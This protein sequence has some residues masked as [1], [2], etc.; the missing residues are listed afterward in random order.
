MQLHYN[1]H[2]NATNEASV[3]YTE[4]YVTGSLNFRGKPVIFQICQSATFTD[5]AETHNNACVF[6]TTTVQ[7]R[8]CNINLQY[9]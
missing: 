6:F 4:S 5:I 3:I 7:I 1:A 8:N 9:I 2:Y